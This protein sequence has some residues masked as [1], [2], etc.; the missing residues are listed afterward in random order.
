MNYFK[1]PEI[2]NSD[3]KHLFKSYAD[4][5]EYK[6]NGQETTTAMQ[7]GTIFHEYVLENKKNFILNHGIL[8]EIGGKKPT[9]T[10]KY[11]EWAETRTL[12]ILSQEDFELLVLMKR[13]IERT[14]SKFILKRNEDIEIEKEIYFE[15]FGV[16]CRSKLDFVDMKNKVVADLKTIAEITPDSIYKAVRW[17]YLTQAAFYTQAV[18]SLEEFSDDW[19]FKFVFV[20]K[21]AP[22]KAVVV[23]VPKELIEQGILRIQAILEKMKREKNIKNGYEEE[24]EVRL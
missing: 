6:E 5:K 17:N 1:R 11:K 14:K 10:K 9:A 21:K 15:Q 20:E 24:M 13:S 7:F 19:K 18:E 4:Y 8:T 2:S 22:Y 12:P 3:L 16:Q 23:E